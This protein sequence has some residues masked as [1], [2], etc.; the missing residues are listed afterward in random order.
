VVAVEKEKSI[1]HANIEQTT[2]R[3]E[4][5][6]ECALLRV[7]PPHRNV[8]AVLAVCDEPPALVVEYC[9]G[10]SMDEFVRRHPPTRRQM[11]MMALDAARGLQVS[12]EGREPVA[13]SDCVR[14]HLHAH[15]IVHRD[16]AGELPNTHCSLD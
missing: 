5:A 1:T 10:G 3:T 14:Q 16:V 9:A 15:C 2:V 7:L 8:L 13:A 4:F 12:V 6:R 11:L